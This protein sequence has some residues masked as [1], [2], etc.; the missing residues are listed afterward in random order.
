V[1]RAARAVSALLLLAGATP[2]AAFVRTNTC[3]DD[4][5]AGY[6]LFLDPPALTYK[7]SDLHVP[8][9]CASGD[10]ATLE[11]LATASVATW[12]T[13]RVLPADPRPCTSLTVDYGGPAAAAKAV[14]VVDGQNLIVFRTKTCGPPD[15]GAPA[16][17]PCL[18]QGGCANL[19]NC[20]EDASSLGVV[21]LALTWVSF[22]TGSGRIADAD[23]ELQDWNGKLSPSTGHYFT[24]AASGPGCDASHAP[25]GCIE[26]DVGS[27][28][29]H[30]AGHM[31]GLDHVTGVDA[32]M[33]PTLNRGPP[34]SKRTLRA[35]DVAG[36]CS[37][38]P[39]GQG[40]VR[41]KL[42]GWCVRPPSKGCGCGGGGPA[43]LGWL[44]LV[45]FLLRRGARPRP[46]SR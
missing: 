21:T 11:T 2:A 23:M 36:V 9:G 25:A 46:A 18:T 10:F 28:V 1:S 13:A 22:E 45:P 24:C 41:E 31:I 44:A 30:E 16:G 20:W 8:L 43:A 5:G 15:Q 39:Y 29:T 27:V 3:P 38:Y 26:W 37:I 40:A 19:Y 32:V 42:P 34:P 35:D 7:L 12:A 14:G 33:N 4:G 6:K 17:A